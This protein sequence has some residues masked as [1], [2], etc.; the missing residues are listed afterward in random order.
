MDTNRCT[1]ESITDHFSL[2]RRVWHKDLP[3]IV[4]ESH[5]AFGWKG[6]LAVI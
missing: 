2:V 1:K 3:K 5:N 6:P 4:L